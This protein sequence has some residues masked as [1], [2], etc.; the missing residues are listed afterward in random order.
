MK[1][2]GQI[3]WNA[4]TICKMSKTYW[5]TGNLR[6]ERRSGESFKGSIILFVALIGYLPELRETEQKFINWKEIITRNFIGY[7]LFA[8]GEFGKKIFWSLI[9]KNWKI[10]RHRNIFHKTEYKRGPDNP[11]RWRVCI[12]CGRLFTKIIRK[13]LRILRTHSETGIH[14]KEIE[15]QRRISWRQGRVSTWRIKRWR[16][17]Q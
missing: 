10:W 1:N 13:K 8:E 5:Q 14:R 17:N 4:F 16:R 9:L 12:S 7:A 11:K 3:P 2:E 6:Y 15:S